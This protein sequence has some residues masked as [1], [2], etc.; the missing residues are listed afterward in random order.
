M[1]N[2]KF[3][4]FLG[5]IRK[6]GNLIAGYN[7]CEFE[8]K[9]DKCKL[10]VIAEDCTDNTKKKFTDICTH[11]NVPYIIEGKKEKIGSTIGK[12]PVSVLGIKDEGMSKALLGLLQQ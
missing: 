10:V 6:S 12:P 4:S 8:I 1:I 3:Y 9:K 5:I 2:D 11:R 7:N